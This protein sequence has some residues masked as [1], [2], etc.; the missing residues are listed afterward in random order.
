MYVEELGAHGKMRQLGRKCRLLGTGWRD[1]MGPALIPTR[2][3]L[4]SSSIPPGLGPPC[5]DPKPPSLRP[6][7][8]AASRGPQDLGWALWWPTRVYTHIHVLSRHH[9]SPAGR[10]TGVCE[11]EWGEQAAQGCL[12]CLPTVTRPCSLGVGVNAFLLVGF[13]ERLQLREEGLGL[14]ADG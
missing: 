10:G 2:P 1:D 5:L 14:A 11:G 4:S 13:P 3:G 9:C 7:H 8:S 12:S 6:Q